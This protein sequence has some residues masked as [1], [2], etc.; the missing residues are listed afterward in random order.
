MDKR[1]IIGIF[2]AQ[3]LFVLML[4]LFGCF[5]PMKAPEPLAKKRVMDDV[6]VFRVLEQIDLDKDGMKEIIAI[7]ATDINSTGVK[8]IKF[9]NDGG[10]VIFKRVFNTPNVEF[11]MRSGI[12]T[13]IVQE[14]EQTTGCAWGGLKSTYRWDGKAFAPPIK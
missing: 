11:A 8:V 6:L 9:H 2:R 12:P 3:I 5:A 1:Q 7:Y 13:L 4:L 14:K 10:D